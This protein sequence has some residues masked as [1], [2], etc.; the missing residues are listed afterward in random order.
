MCVRVC[1]ISILKVRLCL[2]HS[3]SPPQCIIEYVVMIIIFIR[4]EGRMDR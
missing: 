1:I 3:W 4:E 2:N